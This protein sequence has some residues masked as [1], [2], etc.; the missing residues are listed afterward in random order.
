[1]ARLESTCQQHDSRELRLKAD[2]VVPIDYS[3]LVA[4]WTSAQAR[5][6][7]QAARGTWLKFII[8]AILSV[9]LVNLIDS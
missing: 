5:H 8:K 7:E 9:K 1:M 4:A 6:R 3:G 2:K